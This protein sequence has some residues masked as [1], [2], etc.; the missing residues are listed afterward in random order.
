MGV[1]EALVKKLPPKALK[2]LLEYHLLAGYRTI[3]RRLPEGKPIATE[4]TLPNGKPADVTVT[5]KVSEEKNGAVLGAAF[6]KDALGRQF[7][8]VA[9]N[10]F[11]GKV[12]EERAR[13]DGRDRRAG[14]V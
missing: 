12:C 6:V 4:L 10:F 7:E 8:V 2:Q 13:G 14:L 11:Y 5:Y 9:P 1:T 3:P